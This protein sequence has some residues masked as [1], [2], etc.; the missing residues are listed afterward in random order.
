MKHVSI[1]NLV[2][3]KVICGANP[4]YGHSHFSEARDAEYSGRFDDEMIERT[5]Q[6][7]VSLGINAVES[8]ANERI[9]SILSRLRDRNPEPIR[10]VGSTRIDEASEIKSHQKK[11]ALL[12]EKRAE[13]C[14][15][16]AQY[17]DRPRKGDSIGGL[18]RL[19]DTIHDAGLLA[20]ISTHRVETV[21]L[22]E[23]QGYGID[24][25][26]FPLNLSGFVYPGYKGTET[27]Q[28][29]VDVV[30][31]TPKP[32]VL[33]KTLGAGRIPPDEGLQFIAE[34]AKP[35]DVVSIG[36]GTEDEVSES[37]ELVE[38]LF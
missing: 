30:R 32:F 1:G 20:G 27:V 4:F 2:F 21:E 5:I 28:E 33:I 8:S 3:S 6:R 7:C 31:G 26:L 18:A 10:F 23:S 16:H 15:I 9:I 13:V 11:L 22:C 17:V 35:E 14:V 24:T 36:F 34:N 25:Y 19:V 12:V 37:V 38:K 29:R